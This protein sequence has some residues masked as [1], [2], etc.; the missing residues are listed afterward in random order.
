[1]FAKH[2]STS[3]PRNDRAACVRVDRVSEEKSVHADDHVRI[4]S[5]RLRNSPTTRREN[6]VWIA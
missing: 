3:E 4:A 6:S 1:M 5:I 2:N